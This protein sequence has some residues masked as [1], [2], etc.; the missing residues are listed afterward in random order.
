MNIQGLKKYLRDVRFVDFCKSY[1]VIALCE[2][3]QET[4]N[5]FQNFLPDFRSFD[6]MRIKRRTAHRG[7]GGVTVFIRDELLKTNG[8]KRIFDYFTECVIFH[9]DA[10][11]F[12]RETD[13]V[14]V[15]T[16]VVLQ[17][18]LQFMQRRTMVYFY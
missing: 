14:M 2:T 13:V 15:F 4:E 8:I 3:W 16:Y 7:S 12:K 17:E 10:D 9:F 18:S 5:E 6:C 1:D 11:I